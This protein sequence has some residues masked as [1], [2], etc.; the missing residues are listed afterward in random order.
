MPKDGVAKNRALKNRALK[1]HAMIWRFGPEQGIDGGSRYRPR[2]AGLLRECI[3]V[4]RLSVI[5][6]DPAPPLPSNHG[7]YGASWR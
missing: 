5:S 4:E 7:G 3:C 6:D 2:Q 1:N